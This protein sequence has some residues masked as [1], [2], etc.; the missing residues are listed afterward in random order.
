[1]SENRY[2]HLLDKYMDGGKNKSYSPL[3]SSEEKKYKAEGENR[4]GDLLKNA[5]PNLKLYEDMMK[6][7]EAG[8]EI[9]QKRAEEE[10]LAGLR[11]QERIEREQRKLQERR[12]RNNAT[13]NKMLENKKA[14]QEAVEQKKKEEKERQE[15]YDRVQR[16]MEI[17]PNAAEAYI[18]AQTR[19]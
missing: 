8:R 10:Y 1:M 7:E 6:V 2:G 16:L 19:F 15:F 13:I 4:Y 5:K 18:K 11:R 3:L 14:K 9:N 12:D 17:S